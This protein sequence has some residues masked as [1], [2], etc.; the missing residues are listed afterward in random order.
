MLVGDGS[1]PGAGALFLFGD[2]L[3]DGSLGSTGGRFALLVR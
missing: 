3:S 1:E 2:F